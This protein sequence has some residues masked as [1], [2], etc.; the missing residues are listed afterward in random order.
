MA[1]Q[2]NLNIYYIHTA[3][4][5]DRVQFMDKFKS[6]ISKYKFKNIKTVNIK[7]ITDFE[8]NQISPEY[9]L[10][11]IDYTHLK[12]NEPIDESVEPV[13]RLTFYNN[14]LKRIHINQLSNTL[15]HAKAL[16]EIS[17]KSQDNDINII[18][19]D[20]V[21]F[22][23]KVSFLLEKLF[24]DLPIQ[25]NVIFLGL[26][27][28]IDVNKRENIKYQDTREVF[29]VLPYCDSYIVSTKIA[30]QLFNDYFPIR[31]INNIQLSYVLEKNKIPSKLTLSNLFMDGSKFGL[32]LSSLTP[33]NL[34]LFN[35]DYMKM[36]NIL[37]NDILTSEHEKE[38]APILKNPEYFKNPDFLYLKGLY[39]LKNNQYNETKKIFDNCYKM[40]E[41]GGCILNNES[42]FL[43]E[44]I[45]LSKHFQ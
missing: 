32:F 44:Y 39:Y 15:K 34:L 9:I 30:K 4:L 2:K 29:R 11:I 45:K 16:E 41:T 42:E 19:E 23:D 27:S 7:T 36:R 38:L 33:T 17:L 21:L 3:S 31:Y 6:N 14:C 22:D 8:P 24:E 13:N 40:Y 20:D 25:D 28:N 43:K 5:K 12:E 26:P 37:Q 10:K 18:L 1:S 35:G